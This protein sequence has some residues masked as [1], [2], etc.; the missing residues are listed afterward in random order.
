MSPASTTEKIISET[1]DQ[2]SSLRICAPETGIFWRRTGSTRR[3]NSA[4]SAIAP[5]AISV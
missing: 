1:T 4:S 2:K 3:L 5:P